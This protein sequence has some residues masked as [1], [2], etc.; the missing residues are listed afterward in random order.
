M[1]HSFDN[2]KYTVENNNGILTALRYGEPWQD[3]SGNN[4]VYWMLVEVDRLKAENQKLTDSLRLKERG[5]VTRIAGG[6]KID[7][8]EDQKE[9]LKADVSFIPGLKGK[10]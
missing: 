3:L 6:Y 7:L 1:K 2:G 8:T 9:R 4:L 10:E 5:K